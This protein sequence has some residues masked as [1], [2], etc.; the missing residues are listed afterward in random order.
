VLGGNSF[1]FAVFAFVLSLV[2]SAIAGIA[3]NALF[4]DQILNI[5]EIAGVQ[6]FLRVLVTLT[7]I[8]AYAGFGAILLGAASWLDGRPAGFGSCFLRGL[9]AYAPLLLLNAAALLV[10]GAGLLLL[11][12]PGAF[13]A[14]IIVVAGPAMS[15]ERV[16][17][18]DAFRRSAYLTQGN[19]WRIFLIFVVCSIADYAYGQVHGFATRTLATTFGDTPVS[20]G[21]AAMITG[22]TFGTLK[23]MVIPAGLAALYS[24]LRM[25]REGSPGAALAQVFD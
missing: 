10:L 8:P 23:L 2:P 6:V 13:L 17:L 16:G 25:L 12:V 3:L 4:L 5:S 14:T 11:I 9:T 1:R 15:V 7:Q 22:S 21:L 24:E 19:R 20:L 18:L